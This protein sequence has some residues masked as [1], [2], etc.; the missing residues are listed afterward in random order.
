MELTLRDE[1][2]VTFGTSAVSITFLQSL[3]SLIDNHGSVGEFLLIVDFTT[4]CI[5]SDKNVI[6][7]N[8]LF[9]YVK[10]HYSTFSLR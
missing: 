2:S 10:L 6:I 9:L 5:H 7:Q 8:D 3:L 1:F 4:Y